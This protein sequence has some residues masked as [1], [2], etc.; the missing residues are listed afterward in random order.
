MDDG[1]GTAVTRPRCSRVAQD[2][3]DICDRLRVG[4]H[5][6]VSTPKRATDDDDDDDDAADDD[7][8]TELV[9]RGFGF[10]GMKFRSANGL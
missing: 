2:D 6:K 1:G 5:G 8:G 3:D 7:D 10:D 4:V 9:N